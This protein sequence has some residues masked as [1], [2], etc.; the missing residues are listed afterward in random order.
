MTRKEYMRRYLVGY[1]ATKLGISDGLLL[2][3]KRIIPGET[4][5]KIR[6]CVWCG[7]PHKYACHDLCWVAFRRWMLI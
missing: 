4:M 3:S 2:K 6:R 7:A 1:R 5:D